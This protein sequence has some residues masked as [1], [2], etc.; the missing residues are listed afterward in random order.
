MRIDI[1][2]T[3][4]TT[5]PSLRKIVKVQRI[6]NTEQPIVVIALPKAAPPTDCKAY[7]VRR[8]R[9]LRA[10]RLETEVERSSPTRCCSDSRRALELEYL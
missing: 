5:A 2:V 10:V 3:A 8:N 7:A 9:I 1:K 4:K 6:K